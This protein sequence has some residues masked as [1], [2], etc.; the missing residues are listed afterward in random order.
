MSYSISQNLS[1][2]QQRITDACLQNARSPQEVNLVAVSKF[3][4][5]AAVEAA[6]KAGQRLFGENRVQEATAKFPALKEA[7][8]DLQLH[9]IGGLQ[10]NK[11]VEACRIANMIE[12]LDRPSLADALEKASQKIGRLPDLLIQVNTGNE[13]QKY[14][15][16]KEEAEFFIESSLNRFGKKIRGLM[17]I[18]PEEENPIPHFHYLKSLAKK[19]NLPVISMGMSADFEL[20]IQEGATLVRVGSAIFGNRPAS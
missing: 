19:N 11:A 16:P 7:Y 8:P 1:N 17:C 12:T 10:T 6:L 18:P 3:H 5:Q 14:G 20:A 2:I 15:I 9:I 13:P 4:P